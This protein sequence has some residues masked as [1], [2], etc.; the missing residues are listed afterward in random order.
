M[1]TKWCWIIG[2]SVSLALGQFVIWGIGWCL[3]LAIAHWVK[4]TKGLRDVGSDPTYRHVGSFP[5]L[6]GLI[7]RL[8]FTVLIGCGLEA[9]AGIAGPLLI[10]KLAVGWTGLGNIKEPV[11][12]MYA[13]RSLMLALLSLGFGI[14]GGLIVHSHWLRDAIAR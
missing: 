3:K 6:S 2:L 9:S 5:F 13:Q 14:G 1:T 11:P 8:C 4:R 7:E 12:R 10:V